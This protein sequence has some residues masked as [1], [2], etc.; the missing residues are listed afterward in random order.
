MQVGSD[1][2]VANYVETKY[3]AVERQH[4]ATMGFLPL[5]LTLWWAGSLYPLA[6]DV[7]STKFYCW[8]YGTLHIHRWSKFDIKTLQH[9]FI[10]LLLLQYP[11]S[12]NTHTFLSYTV[13]S[14]VISINV[15]MYNIFQEPTNTIRRVNVSMYIRVIP[16]DLFPTSLVTWIDSYLRQ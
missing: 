9:C 16:W 11:S 4:W 5:T 7:Y 8:A 15:L 13:R 6:L 14:K 12:L 2:H 10:A 1:E 3:A